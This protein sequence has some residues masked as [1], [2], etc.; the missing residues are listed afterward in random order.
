MLCGYPPF[1]A[2]SDELILEKI[3]KGKFSFPPEEWDSVSPL[4]KDLVTKMLEFH[5][6]KRLS[7]NEALT[8]KWLVSNNTKTVD[9]N[10]SIKCL[11]NMKK[12]HAERKLQQSSLTYIVNNLLSK[13][14][15]NDLLELFQQF[16]TNGDGVLTKEEILHGYQTIM[17]F[18][19]AEREVQRI[20]TEVDIDKSG[21]IDYNEFVLATI[22][23][24]KLL[25]KEKLE[26]TFR[27]FD[28][29]GNGTI[30]GD[31]IK[32]VLGKSVD[33][34]VLDDMIKEVDTNGDG[35]IS[36]VEFKEMMLKFLE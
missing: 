22:N 6:S 3:K 5:P 20:M 32:A 4:A 21:T 26:A 36:L 12:F 35:E 33:M 18:D 9:K 7:A 14:E 28:K 13:E 19:Y 2:E 8:H 29:D 25:N 17:P 34:K 24:Q 10:L 31:E 1:N 30:S 23:K 27:M 11:K 15:K 16:D